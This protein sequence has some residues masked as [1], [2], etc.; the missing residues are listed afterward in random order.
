MGRGRRAAALR[1]VAAAEVRP[2]RPW[3]TGERAER[4]RTR[5]AGT[6]Y[7]LGVIDDHTHLVYCELHSSETAENVTAILR[8]AVDCIAEQGCG[9]V[10]AVMSDTTRP[11]PACSSAVCWPSSAPARSSPRPTPS[12]GTEGS[13]G[14]F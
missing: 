8:R 10:Q 7:V 5:E 13:S 3:A 1:R 4:D 6:T 12:A 2:A 9:P 11:T 14:S